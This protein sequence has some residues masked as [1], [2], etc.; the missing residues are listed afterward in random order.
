MAKAQADAE[1]ALGEAITPTLEMLYR[2]HSSWLLRKIA[3]QFGADR[4]E[5][6]AQE[7]YIR[8]AAYEGQTVRNPRA[9][10]MQ[11]ALRAA[12][13]RSRR[14]Q[15]RPPFAGASVDGVAE[16]ADQAEQLAL[17]QIVLRLPPKLRDVFLLSRIAG[18]SYLE[19]SQR[20]GISVKTVEW[21]MTK[22]LRHCQRDFEG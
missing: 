9:L 21:R 19:I 12:I 6:L 4:A 10:L 7:T 13:D 17:K 18:L 1:F 2:Q 16:Q 11:I 20:L 3:R 15:V 22:A 5:D 14:E 8:A